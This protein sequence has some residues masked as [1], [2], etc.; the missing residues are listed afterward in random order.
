MSDIK[1][2]LHA[3]LFRAP[4]HVQTVV[5]KTIEEWGEEGEKH[6]PINSPSVPV[7][8]PTPPV[9]TNLRGRVINNVMRETFNCIKANPGLRNKE[10]ADALLKQ[11]FKTTSVTSIPSQLLHAGC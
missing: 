5:Q 9:Q 7:P 1:S 2:A 3:A 4:T 11:G 10:I 8:M 6:F